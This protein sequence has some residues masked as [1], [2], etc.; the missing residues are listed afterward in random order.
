MQCTVIAI[1]FTFGYFFPTHFS[2]LYIDIVNDVVMNW[3]LNQMNTRI[4]PMNLYVSSV[5]SQFAK[6]SFKYAGA[7]AWNA[8][9]SDFKDLYIQ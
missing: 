9:P 2:A 3:N 6:K 8:V 4:H 1:N 7:N 5:T